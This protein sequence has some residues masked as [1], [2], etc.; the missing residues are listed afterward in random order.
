LRVATQRGR[1]TLAVTP[2][3][4]QPTSDTKPEERAMSDGKF[5]ELK[6]RA[7]EAVGDLTD[8]DDL[9]DEGKVDKASGSV[10]DKV[11]KAGDK[12]K[13]AVNPNR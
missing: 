12:V 9:K 2:G 6:G 1:A 5:D 7:K 11:D 13:D 8:N 4:S 3:D 10:K